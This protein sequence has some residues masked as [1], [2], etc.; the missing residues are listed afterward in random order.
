MLQ[1]NIKPK[2]IPQGY[3]KPDVTAE[4]LQ[5]HSVVPV[6]LDAKALIYVSLCTA[7]KRELYN[8]VIEQVTETVTKLNENGEEVTE[9]V[10]TEIKKQVPSGEFEISGVGVEV[11]S[12]QLVYL[13]P[14]YAN[15]IS[16]NDLVSFVCGLLEVELL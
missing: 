14:D 3:L 4:I 7:T 2:A 9:Q 13:N 6:E 15:W 16:D 12:E 10:T 5:I 11:Y 1:L 8:E